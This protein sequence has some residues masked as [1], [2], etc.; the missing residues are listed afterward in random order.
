MVGAEEAIMAEK[1]GSGGAG[2]W[3]FWRGVVRRQDGSGLSVGE[4]CRREDLSPSSFYRWRRRLGPDLAERSGAFVSLGTVHLGGADSG[5]EVV[6][7]CPIRL[8]VQRGF[9]APTLRAVLGILGPSSEEQPGR[10][11]C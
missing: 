10:P 2:R 7:D 4:F 11:S 5:V 6:L 8:R 1:T 3:A 9:D